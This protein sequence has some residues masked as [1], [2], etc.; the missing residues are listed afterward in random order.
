MNAPAKGRL[1]KGVRGIV[2]TRG[3]AVGEP[4]NRELFESALRLARA[5]ESGEVRIIVGER[6]LLCVTIGKLGL[7][8]SSSMERHATWNARRR[9]DA[10]IRRPHAYG[11][12]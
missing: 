4:I 5:T 2:T 10:M 6:M 3:L 12:G 7:L 8:V 11:A 9:A 1:P